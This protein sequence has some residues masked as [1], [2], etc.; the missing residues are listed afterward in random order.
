[1]RIKVEDTNVIYPNDSKF[2]K[3]NDDDKVD[4]EHSSRDLSVKPLPDV[5]NTD[6]SA[7]AHGSN[8]LLETRNGDARWRM[9]RWRDGLME[10]RGEVG[11]GRSGA[12][13]KRR[14]RDEEMGAHD[15]D[16]RGGGGVDGPPPAARPRRDG[17][18][19]VGDGSDRLEDVRSG[20]G[21]VDEG[22][23]WTWMR[24]DR[25]RVSEEGRDEPDGMGRDGDGKWRGS[26]MDERE[27]QECGMVRVGDMDGDE[28]DG[29]GMDGVG[30]GRGRRGRDELG[31]T[32][33]I[34]DGEM[35]YGMGRWNYFC[36]SILM[37]VM[38]GA[39]MIGKI[40][41]WGNERRGM[42]REDG[43]IAVRISAFGV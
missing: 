19:R 11:R 32:I 24:K 4:I 13:W 5:I 1:M 25:E 9:G 40:G 3:D 20:W 29:P 31:V 36:E 43:D 27:G 23:R 26:E 35:M 2:N 37:M 7:Y 34:L 30:C 15:D 39:M 10:C 16:V 38:M 28:Y 22:L 21:R 14:G 8:K 41:V 17:C 12:G 18:R 33:E 42:E 6:V